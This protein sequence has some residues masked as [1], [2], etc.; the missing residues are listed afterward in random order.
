MSDASDAHAVGIT[1]LASL[2]DAIAD[3][4]CGPV[5]SLVPRSTTGYEMGSL[6][7]VLM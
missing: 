2:R 7:L 3:W 6:L 1:L 4:R 5:V